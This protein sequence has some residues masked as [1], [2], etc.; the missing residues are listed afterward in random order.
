MHQPTTGVTG[1]ST[2]A[3]STPTVVERP[4]GGLGRLVAF[5]L[6]LVAVIGAAAALP[7]WLL[8]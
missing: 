3:A 8:G 5:G 7:L 6:G 1:P 2:A 4:S